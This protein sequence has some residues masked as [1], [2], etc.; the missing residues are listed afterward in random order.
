M[1]SRS[2]FALGAATCAGLLGFGYY[3]QFAQGLEPCPLC[4]LQRL[5]FLAFGIVALLGA[6]LGPGTLGTRLLAGLGLLAALAGAGVA[7]RQ[8]WL[9]S[10]P[11]DR[12]PA[13][14]PGLDYM[15]QN[16]PLGKTLAM[17]L[18]GSGECAENAWQFLGL[19]IAA[20]AL[21]WFALLAGLSVYLL[22]RP[23]RRTDSN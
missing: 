16:F 1:S 12:V 13:C 21:V 23:S 10:L 4:V 9:Q 8:V 7:G 6:L 22:L 20:W 19:G 18:R 14:G 2:W 15:V 3:L 17:V 5:A 11:A